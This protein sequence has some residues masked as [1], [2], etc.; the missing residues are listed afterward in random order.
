M[1]EPSRLSFRNGRLASRKAEEAAGRRFQAAA[2][3]EKMVGPLELS[4]Q[5]SEQEFVSCLK[6]GLV[7]CNVINKIQPGAVPKVVTNQSLGLTWENQT[8][9][10]YQYFENIRNF[11]VAVDEL[12]IPSFEAS[13][14]ERDTMEAGSV[15]RI[16]DC[17]LGLK[18]YHDWKQFNKGNSS[19]KY[20]KSPMVSRTKAGIHSSVSAISS[21]VRCLDMSAK[22]EKKIDDQGIQGKVDSLIQA[23]A[24]ILSSSKENIDQNIF[25][26]WLKG[27]VDPVKLFNRI[28]S[29]CLQEQRLNLGED[30]VVERNTALDV[31][32]LNNSCKNCSFCFGKT[33]CN[34][35]QL[36]E[37]QETELEEIKALLSKS[38]LEF[39]ALQSQVQNDLIQIGNQIEGLSAA[40]MG[41]HRAVEENRN[42]HNM[43]QEL[44]GNIQVFC[45]VR[46]VFVSGAKSSI[47]YIGNDGTLILLD[48]LKAQNVRKTFQFNKVF[49]PNATQEEVYKETESLIRSVMDGYNVC[50]FA[51]G[52]TGSGKTYSMCGPEKGSAKDI[53]INSKALNDIFQTS[54]IREDIKYEIQVQ[55]IE[56]YNE[57]VRDLLSEETSTTKLEI[58]NCS[59]NGGLSLPDATM[60]RVKSTSDIMNLMKVGEKNRAFSCTA[61][62][63][64]SSRSHSVLTIHVC[65]R[66]VMGNTL[67]SCLHL[68]DLAGSERVDKSE[69]TGDR[70]KEAQHINKS[71]SC[72]GDVIAALA[73]KSSHIPYRNSKLT[74]LLQNSLGGHGKMLM[75][76]HASPEAESYGET[77]STLKFAQ[78]VSTV[79]LGAAHVNKESR[80]IHDLREQ[81]DSLKKE[82][83]IREQEKVLYLHKMR[84][85]TSL[86]ERKLPTKS[87][88]PRPKFNTD[89]SVTRL[90]R[91]S[92]ETSEHGKSQ[93]QT[94]KE[95]DVR[96]HCNICK[97]KKSNLKMLLIKK[98]KMQPLKSTVK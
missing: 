98:S 15:G 29:S 93:N 95:S 33:S 24:D 50:I 28:I 78:R 48:P 40:A 54:C 60:H 96:I 6:N 47:D 19:W 87:P 42:L 71:L 9:P 85:N 49:G 63:N 62:N 46:P 31:C 3:L 20:A 61:M 79:E 52:Q 92:L 34:H 90:R 81:V 76:A 32:S 5:P 10:A 55:M 66:D 58:R 45:R 23:M 25:D 2:W 89:N 27:T 22:S 69:V 8:L 41:Y 67:Q 16:V 18:D 59:T 38:K 30:S 7:L 72:L 73:Q 83:A 44:R 13:D 14:I 77:I 53:G 17:I 80:E 64:R 57:Q 21:S 91:L 75:L 68:V 88:L 1:E 39:A 97:W 36:L 43:L 86:L 65:G 94:K 82:L 84:E 35:L 12:K 51:Y 11:L 37:S 56:I 74:L 70:L 26:S 4:S